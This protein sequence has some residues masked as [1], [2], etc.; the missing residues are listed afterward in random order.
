MEQPTNKT[1]R[2]NKGLSRP[3]QDTSMRKKSVP[4]ASLFRAFFHLSAHVGI[5]AL[6][7]VRRLGVGYWRGGRGNSRKPE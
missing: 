2:Q 5:W 1:R 6:G 4:L 7:V 3:G